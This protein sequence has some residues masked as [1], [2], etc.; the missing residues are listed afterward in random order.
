[1]LVVF[2]SYIN[3]LFSILIFDCDCEHDHNVFLKVTIKL[4]AYIK[5]IISS[6]VI[7]VIVM[8]EVLV[9]VVVKFFL[10]SLNFN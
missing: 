10:G 2:I 4:F 3:I 1:M 5:I 7:V 9:I 8:F 6:I